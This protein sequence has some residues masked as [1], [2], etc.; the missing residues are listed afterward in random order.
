[1]KHT[2][3]HYVAVACGIMISVAA[4]QAQ[5][6][7]GLTL[8]ECQQRAAEH[9]PLTRQRE[10][11]ARSRDYSMDNVAKGY[12]PQVSISGQ[13]TY[14]S[15]VTQVPISFPGINIDAPSR[16]Q[17]KVYGEVSQTLYDGGTISRQQR[18]QDVS[19]TAEER[20]IDVELYKL[21]E[22]INQ[23][24]FGILL[25][26]EQ[27]AQIAVLKQDLDAAIRKMKAAVANGT[28]LKSNVDVLE[29]ELLKTRQRDIELG[30]A[31]RTYAAMLGL[32]MDR[33]LDEK[34]VLVKPASIQLSNGIDRPELRLYDAQRRIID[35]QY[36][37]I[38]TRS[39]PRVGLFFQGGYGKP[40][41]NMLK[42]SFEAYYVGGLRL[43]WSL[44]GLYSSGSER[45]LLDVNRAI[46]DVQQETFLFNTKLTL[47]QQE[48]DMKKYAE[49]MQ[50]DDDIIVLRAS[51]K[52]TAEAQLE[53]GTITANDYLREVHA[54]DL[55]RQDRLLHG[56]QLLMA[57]Y[58][59]QTTSGK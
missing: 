52:N 14:Q 8:D 21:R 27:R 6:P 9:Y 36:D 16:D 12:L 31:R 32:L 18:I 22:R 2:V 26:D 55:A 59:H 10:L 4:M 7:A 41:L 24:F 23:I 11:L 40:A 49:L 39:M 37:A 50:L 13:A 45:E 28:A 53:G 42:N 46:V 25:I 44:T 17:Y 5:T 33:P 35:A 30:S 51:V 57:Q 56:M 48:T 1:M 3:M 47:T 34:V 20:K 54:E 29:A 43:T 15:D 38:D 58:G 19:T